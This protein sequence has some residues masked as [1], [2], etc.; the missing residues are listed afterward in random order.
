MIAALATI[1]VGASAATVLSVQLGALVALLSLPGG[2][3][4]LWRHI[5]SS[6]SVAATIAIERELS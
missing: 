2:A 4:W 6:R 5:A 3:L 1:G